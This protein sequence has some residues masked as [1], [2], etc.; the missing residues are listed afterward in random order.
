[1]KKTLL[2][3]LMALLTITAAD[4]KRRE[5]PEEIERK[6]RH[7]SGWEWG[8]SARA[9][10][11]FYELDYMRVYNEPPVSAYKSHA[12]FGGNIMLNGGYLINNHWKV[13][14]ELGAQIQYDYTVVPIY[15]TAHYFY[16]K[17]KNCLF[18]F[19]NL[20]TNVLFDK[21]LRFGATGAGGVG[22]RI[23]TPDS[24][25]KYDIMIGYQALMMNPR[26]VIK[27]PFNY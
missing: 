25:N 14:V 1:M 2:L 9:N 11:I 4:A 6:T 22:F 24:P 8:A 17:R 7:Y 21:G 3:V 20:G 18:N 19:L 23:Q 26:P 15:A 13:G 27:E 16:G 5:T 12:K 10:L